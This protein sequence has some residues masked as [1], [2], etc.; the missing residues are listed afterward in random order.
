MRFAF[1]FAKYRGKQDSPPTFILSNKERKKAQKNS[2]SRCF[3]GSG[4]IL[5]KGKVLAPFLSVVIH[6][7]LGTCSLCFQK[8]AFLCV[9]GFEKSFYFEE[10]VS[11]KSFILF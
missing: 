2:F 9:C 3:S 7:F 1:V 6:G 10:S 11:A 5:K 8:F 4:G